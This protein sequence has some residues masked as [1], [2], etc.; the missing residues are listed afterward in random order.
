MAVV[1]REQ[2]EGGTEEGGGGGLSLGAKRFV[3]QTGISGEGVDRHM[4]VHPL[5]PSLLAILGR[6]ERGMLGHGLTR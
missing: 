5:F 2:G 4:Y 6:L 1:R 3:T